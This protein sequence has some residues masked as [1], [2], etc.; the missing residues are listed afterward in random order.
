MNGF[1]PTKE[2]LDRITRG[3]AKWMPR[4]ERALERNGSGWFVGAGMSYPD[5][6]CFEL[7]DQFEV[8]IGDWAPF[9]RLQRLLA[10][11]RSNPRIAAWLQSDRRK[12]K[13]QDGLARYKQDVNRT[14]R[15]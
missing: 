5:V 2:Q 10:A 3:N 13:T 4:L 6:L 12:M 15:R 8:H 14:L 11:L 1:E 7:L 9:P